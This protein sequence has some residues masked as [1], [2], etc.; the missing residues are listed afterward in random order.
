[1]FK[2]RKPGTRMDSEARRLLQNELF[3]FRRTVTHGFPHR[4][5]ALAFDPI[6]R[7]DITNMQLFDND[8]LPY[9][10]N[11]AGFIRMLEMSEGRQGQFCR[12]VRRHFGGVVL[13]KKSQKRLLSDGQTDQAG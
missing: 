7:L 4:P 13:R 12:K 6:L 3:A 2:F 10:W 9:P 8:N 5:S 11:K 1:M